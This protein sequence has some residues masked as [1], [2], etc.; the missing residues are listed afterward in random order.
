MSH[1]K[2][3]IATTAASLAIGLAV[4][5]PVYEGVLIGSACAEVSQGKDKREVVITLVIN[6]DKVGKEG[7]TPN[8]FAIAVWEEWKKQKAYDLKTFAELR[9][10]IN[11]NVYRVADFAEVRIEIKA[12]DSE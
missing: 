9:V 5:F 2:L 1:S 6:R 11:G 7:I 4:A 10:T 12:K 3:C 8:E